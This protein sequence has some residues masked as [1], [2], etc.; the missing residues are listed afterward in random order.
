[1]YLDS[2]HGGWLG[3]EHSLMDYLDL[4]EDLKVQDH[5]R[6]F[7]LNTANYQRYVVGGWMGG[8]ALLMTRST[9]KT[10]N[11]PSLLFS[12]THVLST[13]QRRRDVPYLGP[14]PGR[15]ER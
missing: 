4:L 15:E 8:C 2:S 6:G 7:A 12:L 5:I 9:P 13:P 11:K 1:M 14:L 3:W 10:S